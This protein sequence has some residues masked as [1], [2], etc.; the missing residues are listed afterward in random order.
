MV[1]AS[2][3][4]DVAD[5]D[6]VIVGGGVI[7]MLSV[8]MLADAGLAAALITPDI[9][10][11]GPTGDIGAPCYA[12]TPGSRAVL[13]AVGAWG[14]VDRSRVGR[15]DDMEVWDA[16]SS[17]RIEFEPPVT[18]EGPMGWIIEHQNLIAALAATLEARAS[19]SIHRQMMAELLP[20][21]APG[22]RLHDGSTVR[23][24]LVIGADGAGSA[25]REAAGIE[26]ER[27]PYDQIAI[28]CNVVCDDAH[29][30]VARQRFLVSGPLAFL[31]LPAPNSCSIVWSCTAELAKI[32][33]ADTDDVFCRRLEDALEHKLG[34]IRQVGPR[35][36]FKLERLRVTR[37]VLDHYVL[38]GDA[39]HVVHPLAGQGL[40]LGIMDVAA[41]VECLGPR[42]TSLNWPPTA[43]LR[44]YERW[45]AS[46]TLAMSLVTDGL[47]RLFQSDD[48]MV[49]T[50]RG[51]GLRMTDRMT[52]IKHWLIERAMGI[53]GDIPQIAN[54]LRR[55]N[56]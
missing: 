41:L 25:V 31:P 32:I 29:A 12:I 8:A 54:P 37:S 26:V 40:N 39:A 10:T 17:G 3:D 2:P 44:R 28:V 13:D 35:A 34:E 22:V 46:E 1:M 21:P 33:A 7:G 23:A 45:R 49:R 55:G 6:A 51:A 11:R 9:D 50:I 43:A 20:A 18:H 15:F 36:S 4:C 19:V 56:V 5:Y 16:D 24:R 48:R 53:D 42:G 38:V 52:A 30:G 14:R 47:N 27:I